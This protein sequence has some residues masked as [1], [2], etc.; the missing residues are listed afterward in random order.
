MSLDTKVRKQLFIVC[1][2]LISFVLLLTPTEFV[3]GFS[4]ERLAAPAL[5]AEGLGGQSAQHLLLAKAA[6]GDPDAGSGLVHSASSTASARK[7]ATATGKKQ[8]PKQRNARKSGK[9]QNK[10]AKHKRYAPARP[11]KKKA[12]WA[13]RDRMITSPR[14]PDLPAG[15]CISVLVVGDSLAVG[16]GMTLDSAFE[17]RSKVITRKMGRISSGL[18]SPA[19]Y[20]WNRVLKEMLDREKF[21]LVV[22]VLGANDAHNGPG[23]PEWGRLYGAKFSEFLRIPAE[24]HVRTLVVGLPPMQKP[25]FSRRVQVVN[26]AIRNA[27]QQFPQTCVYID[28]FRRFSDEGGNFTDH[29][30]VKGEWKKVRAEDGV[31]FTGTGYLLFSKMVADEVLR[32]SG[33][34]PTDSN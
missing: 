5:A 27:S 15:A 19:S 14:C 20:D 11:G 34:S 25:D 4:V 16:V 17:G 32:H 26:E 30:K 8:G 31:H 2:G 24:K 10:T 3:S 12:G 28:A 9:I 21:D 13:R 22:V 6:R 1:L 29:I 33:A 18:D 7:E 23:N